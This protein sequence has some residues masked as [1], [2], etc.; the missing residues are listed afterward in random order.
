M[1]SQGNDAIIQIKGNQETLFNIIKEVTTSGR[2]NSLSSFNQQEKRKRN[3]IEYR[4]IEVFQISEKFL[5]FGWEK[6]FKAIIRVRRYTDCWDTKKKQWVLRAEVS[7]YGSTCILDA[8]KAAEIIRMHWHIENKNH[9]VRDVSLGED[10]S[11]IRKN[12]GIFGRLRSLALN[13]LRKNNITNIKE[14]LFLNALNFENLLT[15]EGIF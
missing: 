1:T 14:G 9:Y 13:L 11:R 7:Y 12:P 10:A 15:Y 4:E 3:R 5:P 8:K 6:T 2:L